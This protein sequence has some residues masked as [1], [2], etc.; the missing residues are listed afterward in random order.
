LSPAA[1]ASVPSRPSQTVRNYLTSRQPAALVSISLPK[2]SISVSQRR[3]SDASV[4]SPSSLFSSSACLRPGGSPIW[5]LGSLIA[6]LT[7]SNS[8]LFRYSSELASRANTYIGMDF[9]DVI[10]IESVPLR[11]SPL[12][13]FVSLNV[14]L[15]RLQFIFRIFEPFF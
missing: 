4:R 3:V 12:P 7:L 13:D 15:K 11:K 8:W 5:R 6:V 1:I 2:A 9:V 14:A 10:I